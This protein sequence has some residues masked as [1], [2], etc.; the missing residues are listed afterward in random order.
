MDK[1]QTNKVICYI[2]SA[3]H[4]LVFTHR[5]LPLDEV[6]V[7]VPAGTIRPGEDPAA[8]AL[9]EATEETGLTDLKVLRK[10]GEADYDIT[11]Y[12]RE[13]MRR[14]FYELTT[15]CPVTRRWTSQEPD[16]EGGGQGPLFDCYWIPLE[17]GHVL[18]GGLSNF[19]GALVP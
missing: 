8:A 13:V 15:N 2:V 9:R 19:L 17:Q 1:A 11:P 14:R 10:L 7:Q 18:S 16:P 5:D 3:G 4:L 12:R 6:G